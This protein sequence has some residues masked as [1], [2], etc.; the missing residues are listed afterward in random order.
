VEVEVDCPAPGYLVLADAWAPGW[1]AA[2]D[3]APALIERANLAVR[4]VRVPGGA[5]TVTFLYQPR[6]RVAGPALSLCG[7]LLAAVLILA[8]VLPWRRHRGRTGP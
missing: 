3:G 5:H 6:W 7:I 8:A 4:A 2:V 1:R